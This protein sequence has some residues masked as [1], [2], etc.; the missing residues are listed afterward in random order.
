MR[1]KD[2]IP[3]FSYFVNQLVERHPNLAYIHVT[4]ARVAGSDDREPP[5]NEVSRTLTRHCDRMRLII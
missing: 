4:E 5:T 1:M 2:P 3:T